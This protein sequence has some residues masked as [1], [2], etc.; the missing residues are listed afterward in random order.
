VERGEFDCK[1]SLQLNRRWLS[2]VFLPPYAPELNPVD[3]IWASLKRFPPRL[4]SIRLSLGRFGI[5]GPRSR[6]N[7]LR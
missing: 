1:C 6:W 3:T 5:A 7:R 2:M 4:L